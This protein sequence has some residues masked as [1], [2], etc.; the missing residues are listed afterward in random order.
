MTN[1]RAWMIKGV[2]DETRD[3][4]LEAAHAAGLNVGEWI[5]RVLARAAAEAGRAMTPSHARRNGRL[6]AG[7]NPPLST[8]SKISEGTV[9][10]SSSITK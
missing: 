3:A 1:G 6:Y 10:S 9:S 8:A 2:S 4:T 7:K 5:D